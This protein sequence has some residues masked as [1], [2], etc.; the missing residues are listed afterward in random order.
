MNLINPTFRIKND[1]RNIF[2]FRKQDYDQ[3][4]P[5]VSEIVKPVTELDFEILELD[6]KESR[7][8]SGELSKTLKQTLVIKLQKGN[9]VLDLSIFIP[10]LI[11]DNYIII[12]G[13]KKIPLF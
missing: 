11:N 13:R 9:S 1:E 7:F 8:T 4:L 12:N 10:K 3:I 2:T 6:L 5:V